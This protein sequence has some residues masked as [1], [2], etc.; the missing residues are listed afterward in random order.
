MYW[1]LTLNPC[2]TSCN[3]IVSYF[4][5]R[6]NRSI[7]DNKQCD[8]WIENWKTPSYETP[9]DILHIRIILPFRITFWLA[10]DP[11]KLRGMMRLNTAWTNDDTCRRRTK[12]EF[13]RIKELF[14]YFWITPWLGT[15]ETLH[16][17]YLEVVRKMSN[18]VL[19]D[20]GWIRFSYLQATT[21]VRRII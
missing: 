10:S 11:Q 4:L 18:R 17:S 20:L 2:N 3:E 15:D 13:N 14:W 8:M 1:V 19:R 21:C 16:I 12:D 5:N 9:V 7:T 6:T